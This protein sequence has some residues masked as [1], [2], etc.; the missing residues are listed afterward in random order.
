[1]PSLNDPELLSH[2]KRALKL[3]KSLGIA[4]IR[5]RIKGGI[6]ELCLLF[7]NGLL[8]IDFVRVVLEQGLENLACNKNTLNYQQCCG[9]MG[10]RTYSNMLSVL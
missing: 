9:D 7:R 10:D 1:M 3:K 4:Y 5:M 2:L 8:A 6:D